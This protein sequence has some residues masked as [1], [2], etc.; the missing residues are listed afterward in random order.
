MHWQQRLSDLGLVLPATSNPGG[1]YVSVNIR[2]DIAYVAIQFPI[3]DG[4][5][6]YQGQLGEG[7][8]L[9]DAQAAFQ[10]CALNVLAQIEAKVGMDR[11][12]GL[13][14]IDA[15]YRAAPGW[16][17]APKAVNGASDLFVAVLG[18][19]G[20]HSRA[21]FGVAELPRGFAVGLTSSWTL[22]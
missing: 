7:L 12:M 1:N 15:Y 3:R 18:E 13:N 5:F 6:Y 17:E 16:D 4:I 10:L 9:V 11:I 21:I 8:D 22:A 19:R 20:Q 14:H 2:R